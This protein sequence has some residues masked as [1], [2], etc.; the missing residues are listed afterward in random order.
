MKKRMII[1]FVLFSVITFFSLLTAYADEL[2]NKQAVFVLPLS[3]QEIEE[4]AFFDTAVE[5]VVFP[6][7]L[8]RIGEKAFDKA[9]HLTDVYIPVTT[10]CIADSAFS[11]SSNLKIHGIDGSYANEWANKQEIPFVVDNIWDIIVR[12]GRMNNTRTNPIKRYVTTLV[13]IILFEAFRYSYYEVRSRRPQDRPELN[14]IDYRF[15]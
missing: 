7:G 12:S 2:E 13:L 10:E 8:L 3:L 14:P 11:S 15:P 4:E 9:W 1:L 5:T 6:E